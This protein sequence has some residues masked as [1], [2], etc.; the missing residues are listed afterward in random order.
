MLDG[1]S[2]GRLYESSWLQGVPESRLSLGNDT[3][4]SIT[5]LIW[6]FLER[7]NDITIQTHFILIIVFKI[8]SC[9]KM[10]RHSKYKTNLTLLVCECIPTIQRF[11]LTLILNAE[12]MLKC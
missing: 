8:I 3:I 5:H 10:D 12:A 6:E 9:S 4:I 2:F 11:N 7:V 1:C